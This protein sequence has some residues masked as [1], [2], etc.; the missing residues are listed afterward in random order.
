MFLYI[1]HKIMNKFSQLLS[2]HLISFIFPNQIFRQLVRELNGE[3]RLRV[4]DDDEAACWQIYGPG[5]GFF[6]RRGLNNP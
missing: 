6:T 4:M 3:Y 2:K 1:E 5:D